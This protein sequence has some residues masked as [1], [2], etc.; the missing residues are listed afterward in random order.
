M[1]I[2]SFCRDALGVV[3]GVTRALGGAEGAVGV[4]V[5]R[6]FPFARELG[7]TAGGGGGRA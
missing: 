6:A 4:A 7:A 3:R 1:T 5:A 2:G